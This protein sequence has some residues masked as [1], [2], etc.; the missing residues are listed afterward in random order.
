MSIYFKSGDIQVCGPTEKL[1][2]DTISEELK[3]WYVQRAKDI[4]SDRVHVHAENMGLNY[5]NIRIKTLKSRWGSCSSL[6]NLNFNWVLIMCPIEIIDYV[7][8]HELA[9]LVH[10]NHSAKFW[11]LVEDYCPDYKSSINWLKVHQGIIHL[12]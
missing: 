7:V 1:T 11:S 8:I 10:M 2:Q 3:K 12:M 4:I 9:H 6:R 5:N